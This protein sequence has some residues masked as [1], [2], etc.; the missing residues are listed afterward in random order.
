MRGGARILIIEA[1]HDPS[2]PRSPS[3]VRGIPSS[4]AGMQTSRGG[5]LRVG[6]VISY[7]AV[8]MTYPGGG[9]EGKGAV[10]IQSPLYVADLNGMT[11]SK[12]AP[13][14]QQDAK[15][16][17]TTEAVYDCDRTEVD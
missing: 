1:G 5:T 7:T 14:Q 15:P 17:G 13:S 9:G 10:A 16:L 3:S 8:A 2:Q 12:M 4:S 6:L 11:I